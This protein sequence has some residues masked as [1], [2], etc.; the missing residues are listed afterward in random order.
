MKTINLSGPRLSASYT[1]AI[2]GINGEMLVGPSAGNLLDV[3]THCSD[4]QL[5]LELSQLAMELIEMR[6]STA[7]DRT[8][9][10]IEA[11]F[12]ESII[13][14]V[15]IPQRRI[16][17][18]YY[19]GAID[20]IDRAVVRTSKGWVDQDGRVK[21][22][23]DA[24]LTQMV[25]WVGASYQVAPVLMPT[26]LENY[27]KSG[28]IVVDG[29]LVATR[30]EKGMWLSDDQF[31]HVIGSVERAL[32]HSDCAVYVADDIR[33][34]NDRL[35]HGEV[36]EKGAA[37]K[38]HLSPSST[39]VQSPAIYAGSLDEV[40][41][42][43]ANPESS[44]RL[45]ARSAL[46]DHGF[47]VGKEQQGELYKVEFDSAS[48]VLDYTG[49]ESISRSLLQ[50]PSP[51]LLRALL[52]QTALNTLDEREIRGNLTFTASMLI[53]AQ[54]P[55]EI[56]SALLYFCQRA[57][58]SS[59]TQPQREASARLMSTMVQA[60]GYDIMLTDPQLP[61]QDR[62]KGIH[63]ILNNPSSAHGQ[64]LTQLMFEA[65]GNEKSVE[66]AGKILKESLSLLEK[67][68]KAGCLPQQ[69]G[70]HAISYDSRVKI[71][72]TL[73]TPSQEGG[74]PLYQSTINFND[75]NNDVDKLEKVI[76]QYSSGQ[77]V[78]LEAGL[79]GR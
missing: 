3:L 76:A 29:Q 39:S 21:V 42:V 57:Q 10:A 25:D 60:M 71:A 38:S 41:R 45:S 69:T 54:T 74:H 77:Q 66:R 34:W 17:T 65:L 6:H 5:P 64:E 36:T 8:P 73:S 78:A 15:T 67:T 28:Q 35:W 31:V 47:T 4:A 32:F 7:H 43:Y 53:N 30:N 9:Q 1:N 23:P 61:L 18:G 40:L 13:G 2:L 59:S 20:L 49:H 55:I 22:A 26:D 79:D 70:L 72:R 56:H 16:E 62:L 68:M 75:L 11:K 48:S 33:P 44:E 50:R 24:S 51:F 19:A 27:E 14:G 37:P 52:T 12:K 63:S 46:R 58:Q